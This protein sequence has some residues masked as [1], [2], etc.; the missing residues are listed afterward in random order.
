MGLFPIFLKLKGRRCL[1][2]GA[3]KIAQAKA[4]GLLR[5]QASVVVV[6]PEATQW[7]RT[8]A[9]AGVLVWHPRKFAAR[10][11]KGAFLVVVAT[12]SRSA[13]EAVASLCARRAI[14]CNVVDDP[15]HCDF[16]YPSI[17][18]R[19]ALQIAISTG[20]QSP[21]LAHR[22]RV[23]LTQQFGPGFGAWLKNV[24]Q[25]RKQLLKQRLTTQQRRKLLKEIASPESFAQFLRN[26]GKKRKLRIQDGSSS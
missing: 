24:G 5:S 10:D 18:R 15:D 13:N 22:L 1:V 20:G 12:N 7:I 14:L 26:S 4:A 6:G 19:G 23:E 21:S 9:Q 3:G 8:K 2:V 16:F 25:R 11:L 17:V